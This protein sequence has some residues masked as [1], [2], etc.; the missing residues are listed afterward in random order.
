MG[1]GSFRLLSL[2][3]YD[4]SLIGSPPTSVLH[5]P[6]SLLAATSTR[7]IQSYR[8]DTN[9]QSKRTVK[10]SAYTDRENRTT[11]VWLQADISHAEVKATAGSS[12]TT[13]V[14]VSTPSPAPVISR[15]SVAAIRVHPDLILALEMHPFLHHLAVMKVFANYKDWCR[16]V[17]GTDHNHLTVSCRK[18]MRKIL[19]ELSTRLA[20]MAN[21]AL[22]SRTNI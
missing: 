10:R 7:V 12:T 5:N 14:L 18:P 2:D 15:P 3:T 4:Q 11:W 8:I 22:L 1:N 13:A 19:L 9:V 16:A 21:L 6:C 17:G 20:V